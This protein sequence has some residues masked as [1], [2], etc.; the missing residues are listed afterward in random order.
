M[1]AEEGG[2]EN[3][4][5]ISHKNR[6]RKIS[7]KRQ[8]APTAACVCLV[9]MGEIYCT[10]SR[11]PRPT[12]PRSLSSS[13][14]SSSSS[15]L[16]SPPFPSLL[17]L[18]RCHVC[19][20]GPSVGRGRPAQGGERTLVALPSYTHLCKYVRM[21]RCCFLLLHPPL[22]TRIDLA[23]GAPPHFAAYCYNT[24]LSAL[25]QRQSPPLVDEGAFQQTSSSSSLRNGCP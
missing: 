12:D 8:T 15:E 16:A 18:R 5:P 24:F 22:T 10:Q 1:D 6:R 4:S 23:F 11:K 21:D 25:H 3:K 9:A 7:V 2:A 20:D 13:S 14:S 17:A 19:S